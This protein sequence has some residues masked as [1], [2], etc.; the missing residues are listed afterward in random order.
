MSELAGEEGCHCGPSGSGGSDDG[1]S[2]CHAAEVGT[3][4]S[5]LK[6][7][8][9]ITLID[10]PSSASRAHLQP[11]G[12]SIL[13]KSINMTGSARSRLAPLSKRVKPHRS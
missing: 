9:S 4:R 10:M 12:A 11:A 8:L 3:G 2:F 1:E 7:G 5:D 6:R 13:L